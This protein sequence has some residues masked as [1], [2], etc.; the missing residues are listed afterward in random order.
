MGMQARLNAM[1][2]RQSLA[3]QVLQRE[4]GC[5]SSRARSSFFK[6]GQARWVLCAVLSDQPQGWLARFEFSTSRTVDDG[7]GGCQTHRSGPEN[8]KILMRRPEPCRA[9]RRDEEEQ[10]KKGGP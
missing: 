1:R 6:P 8:R 10:N 7:R 3:V 9:R 2:E 5:T 4:A